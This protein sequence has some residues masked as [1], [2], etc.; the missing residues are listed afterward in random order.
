MLITR[1]SRGAVRA[2][3]LVRHK[4][5]HNRL[6]MPTSLGRI[7]RGL[8]LTTLVARTVL[9]P[10]PLFA[11]ATTAAA[12]G[13]D[14]ADPSPR[15]VRVSVEATQAL[16]LA[17]A[18]EPT[19]TISSTSLRPILIGT[20]E[21]DAAAAAAA[22]KAADEAAAA[23]EA[24][25]QAAAA[26]QAAKVQRPV[27]TYGDGEIQQIIRD[28]AA[29]YSVDAGLMLHIAACE[30]GFNPSAHNRSGASGLFQFMYGTYANSPSGRAGLS[31][32]DAQANA[33]AAA[34]KIANGGL[35][36]W[37]ASRHCWGR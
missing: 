35:S 5:L 22:Q 17:R 23:A 20:S 19:L 27:A 32:W 8:L 28:A 7:G 33:E 25:K 15:V 12:A 9:M 18:D 24:A 31:I 3:L 34:F 36:A 4:L 1:I 10:V 13:P 21:A 26:A 30:S 29:L 6:H 14:N 2:S 11:P 37:N 16:H